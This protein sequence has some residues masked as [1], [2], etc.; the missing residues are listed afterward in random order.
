M[1]NDRHRDLVGILEAVYELDQPKERWLEGILAAA[2]AV[3]DH[4]GGIGGVLYDIS[5]GSVRA[6]LIDVAG[7][8]PHV[9][10]VVAE[11]HELPALVPSV[12]RAYGTLMCGTARDYVW[13]REA[14]API[15]AQ[16]QRSGLKDTL[17]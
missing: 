9:R 2:A 4:G 7:P 3:F 5:N 15:C 16:Q 10:E 1:H 17:L 13:N 14:F 8:V 11:L 12:L 6:E